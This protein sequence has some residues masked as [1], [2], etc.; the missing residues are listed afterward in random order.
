MKRKILALVLT[1]VMVATLMPT[2][3]LGAASDVT[4]ET[5]DGTYP[6]NGTLLKGGLFSGGTS[7]SQS[8]GNFVIAQDGNGNKYLSQTLTSANGKKQSGIFLTP[9]EPITRYQVVDFDVMVKKAKNSTGARIHLSAKYN[10]MGGY[11]AISMGVWNSYLFIY[12]GY[13]KS[14]DDTDP[15]VMLKYSDYGI[16]DY[17]GKNTD[18]RNVKIIYDSTN[19]QFDV[20]MDGKLVATDIPT[21]RYN[22]SGEGLETFSFNTNSAGVGAE[23]GID[24]FKMYGVTAQEANALTKAGLD[25][26]I[27]TPDLY[28]NNV[29]TLP[30]S[31][32]VGYTTTGAPNASNYNFSV[33]DTVNATISRSM[34]NTTSS[35][36]GSTSTVTVSNL[37]QSMFDEAIDI[38]LT[39]AIT[40]YDD[41]GVAVVTNATYNLSATSGETPT[42]RDITGTVPE[43]VTEALVLPDTYTSAGMTYDVSWRSSSQQINTA[44]GE[45]IRRKKSEKATLTATFTSGSISASLAFPVTILA[46][47]EI[48]FQEYFEPIKVEGEA[49]VDA[50]NWNDWRFYNKP[51]NAQNVTATITADPKNKDNRAVELV[52]SAADN[53]QWA[54]RKDMSKVIDGKVT[55]S[56]KIYMD[57]YPVAASS[58][59]GHFYITL[60]QNN[61]NNR[62]IVLGFGTDGKIYN[63]RRQITGTSETND[64]V[65]DEYQYPVGSW[66][67]VKMVIDTEAR[68]YDIYIN[69]T[70]I[71][72]EPCSFYCPTVEISQ[73]RLTP[74]EFRYIDFQFFKTVDQGTAYID[75]VVVYDTNNDSFEVTNL[76]TDEDSVNSVTFFDR[77]C[78]AE[79]VSAFVAVYDGGVLQDAKMIDISSFDGS[80]VKTFDVPSL[81]VS[82]GNVV[83]VFVLEHSTL[84]PLM[85]A[86]TMGEE[87]EEETKT[88]VYI[89]GDSIAHT[90]E[91]AYYPQAGWGQLLENYLDS[92]IVVENRAMGGRSSRSFIT[93]G[94][95]D[96]IL[97]NIKP[98]DYLLVQFG[99]NDNKD[100][101]QDVSNAERFTD[102]ET[103]Y[104]DYLSIYV[105][106]AR[107]KGAIPV[108]L[109]SITRYD[110]YTDDELGS[111]LGAYPEEMI[112]FADANNVPVID[113]FSKSVTEVGTWT[114]AQ[115]KDR[116][117]YIEANDSRYIDDP[118]FVSGNAHYEETVTKGNDYVDFT[119]FTF[120]GSN[121]WAEMIADA[122]AEQIGGIF[123]K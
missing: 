38:D 88:A 42:F 20:I 7:T 121:I 49:G 39:A 15:L 102:P 77:G 22:V 21:Q 72:S 40:R 74:D 118:L 41:K 79:K 98:G 30:Y 14:A 75:D 55:V 33:D 82:E 17:S 84:K 9:T 16:S 80:Y 19:L 43:A 91:D 56:A 34:Y 46:D 51:S 112:K 37:P 35:A 81:A 13:N 18:W 10:T 113:M 59:V 94:R 78:E 60:N 2:V 109:T 5:F 105:N 92:D 48:H 66:M 107:K 6:A 62:F 71:N 96:D 63:K 89:A 44:T 53:Y 87:V 108:M 28:K 23:S 27:G 117:L 1:F 52:R 116:Y 99:H 54:L 67:D 103:T 58:D 3:I 106:E 36:V 119:H 26:L 61:L 64:V 85:H 120:E 110:T 24:N 76:E 68:G 86:Y 45:V 69:D 65:N 73:E 8:Y 90:Y 4:A 93:E 101:I 47:G 97:Y 70:K 95:L 123:A 25:N 100:Y 11:T 122:L 29:I 12:S 104:H 57:E 115:A 50:S 111:S 32:L 83:K 114:E 31:G